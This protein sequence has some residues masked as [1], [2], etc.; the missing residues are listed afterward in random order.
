MF[1]ALN[2]NARAVIFQLFPKITIFTFFT[3][4]GSIHWWKKLQSTRKKL[5][6]TMGENASVLLWDNK[7]RFYN[8]KKKQVTTYPLKKW[9]EVGS[10]PVRFGDYIYV[11]TR[12]KID[13]DEIES[14]KTVYTRL[15]KIGNYFGVTVKTDPKYIWPI[16]RSI[17]FT[18]KGI[19]LIKPTYSVKIVK[20]GQEGEDINEKSAVVFDKIL[21]PKEKPTFV[22]IPAEAVKYRLLIDINA[23]N[24][25]DLTV[26]ET[27]AAVDVNKILQNHFYELHLTDENIKKSKKGFKS[28]KSKRK[29]K[30][31]SSGKNRATE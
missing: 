18:F 10:N 5:P 26:E 31:R 11:V 21:G 3:N 7:I 13:D 24:Q 19:N 23:E 20:G 9:M 1:C 8:Y 6:L 14:G 16:N 30:N 2:R 29:D 4:R 25:K 17:R 22:W 27:F 12:D 28:K 15:S